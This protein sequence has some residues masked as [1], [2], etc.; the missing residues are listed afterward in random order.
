MP[1]GMNSMEISVLSEV[2][3]WSDSFKSRANVE[4]KRIHFLGTTNGGAS[5]CIPIPAGY[6][7]PE[8]SEL[9]LQCEAGQEPSEDRSTCVPCA[10]GYYN[11]ESGNYCTKCPKFTQ[12]SDDRTTCLS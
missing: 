12:P 4:I 1:Y 11:P 8:R 9:P 5:D 7:A 10:N 3:N 2:E 6:Y